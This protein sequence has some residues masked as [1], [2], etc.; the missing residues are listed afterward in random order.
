[1]EYTSPESVP[2]FV[3]CQELISGLGFQLVELVCYKRQSTWHVRAVITGPNGVGINECTKVHRALLVRL[4]ALLV[5]QDMYIE[6]TSPGLDRV[7]KNAYEF[8]LFVGKSVKVWNV[9]ISDWMQ[10][11]IVSATINSVILS[12]DN[13]NIDIKYEK[14][15][16]AKLTS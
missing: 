4:E 9:D 8:A 2:Y 1:M 12:I 3:D 7:L 11:T 15:N 16:K 6:V 13:S 5:S 14:I 10:G